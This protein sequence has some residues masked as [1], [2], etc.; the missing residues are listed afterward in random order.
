MVKLNQT[1]FT[2]YD[3]ESLR[4]EWLYKRRLSMNDL[5]ENKINTIDTIINNTEILEL[6]YG[7][8]ISNKKLIKRIKGV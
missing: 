5:V 1:C 6:E 2:P 3:W 7:L 8:N 4:L